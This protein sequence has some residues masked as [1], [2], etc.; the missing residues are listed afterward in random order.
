MAEKIGAFFD[1]DETLLDTESSRLGI[2]Y[3]W[4]RRQVSRTFILKAFVAGFL[5]KRHWITDEQTAKILLRLYRNRRLDE[6]KDGSAVF[7]RE[8]LKPRLAPRILAKVNEHKD[9][10][11]SMV[12]I[13]GSIRYMLEPVARDLGFEHLL[14]TDL[15]ESAN[16]LLTGKP[17]GPLCLD[18][19]K[20]HL[21]TELAQ[22]TGIDLA[23]S[24]AYGNHQADLPLLELV[25]FPHTVE[26]S[27]PLL[28]VAVAR[29]WPILAYR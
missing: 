3:L 8:I 19:T 7:Y 27:K 6:F 1:F 4:E 13:S 23:R 29:N 11:H 20:Q 21:A 17:K 25:G 9:Q 22:R 16:G 2:K 15:E 18:T 5:Y 14:C 10:G 24:Y 12:L 26:P 28:K